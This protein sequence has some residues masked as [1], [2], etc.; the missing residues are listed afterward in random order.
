[1]SRAQHRARAVTSAFR[2]PPTCHPPAW[3]SA[4]RRPWLTGQR[5]L[6]GPTSTPVALNT[7][8]CAST[9]L[10]LLRAASGLITAGLRLH[11]GSPAPP[12]ALCVRPERRALPKRSPR[13]LPRVRPSRWASACRENAR[14]SQARSF[15][16]HLGQH[17]LQGQLQVPLRLKLV[18]QTPSEASPPR[19]RERTGLWLVNLFPEVPLTSLPLTFPFPKPMTWL[20]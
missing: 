7:Q 16:A 3:P 2:C 12:R 20:I 17:V 15:T 18:R 1:M 19:G 9:A 14:G 10:L 13:R 5:A 8:G 11:P 6:R 4:P